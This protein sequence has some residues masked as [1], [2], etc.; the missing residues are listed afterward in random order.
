MSEKVFGKLLMAFGH[1]IYNFYERVN[2][3][4]NEVIPGLSNEL[5]LEWEI[6]LGLPDECSSNLGNLEQ[7]QDAAHV[8]YTQKYS[9]MSKS[10]F[11]EYAEGM[12]SAITI[13]DLATSGPFRVNKARVNRTPEDGI[14]GARLWSAQATFKFI[15]KIL[16][17]DSNKNYLHCRFLQMKPA[18]MQM[19]WVEVDQ[20]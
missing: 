19:I 4:V 1:E 16:E 5:L 20:L 13:S 18:H 15:V 2:N 7:R 11:L 17:T 14:D 3:L 10:F 8:K 9:G 12:G 6:D